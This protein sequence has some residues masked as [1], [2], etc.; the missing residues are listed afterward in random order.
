MATKTV[1]VG[2]L[3]LQGNFAE[4]AALLAAMSVQ[5][6]YVRTVQDLEQCT[7][8][9]IPGGESTTISLLLASTGLDA[10]ITDRCRAS[11]LSVMGICAGA[12]LVATKITGKNPPASLGL[13]DI[14]IDRNAYGNQLESFDASLIVSHVDRPVRA[15][16]IRAP[17]ITHVGKDVEVLAMHGEHPV[18]VR[19]GNV[20][21]LTCHPELR[22]EESIHRLFI[23]S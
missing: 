8:L 18:I 20:W 19:A 4:H 11:T 14:T 22:D 13:I 9:I 17:V 1:T 10:A 6:Q 3:A 2:I 21:A 7:H 12:I 5:V 16:F 23:A 15:S